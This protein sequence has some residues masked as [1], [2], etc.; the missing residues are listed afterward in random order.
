MLCQAEGLVLLDQVAIDGTKIEA[1][2]SKKQ[3]YSPE[4][5]AKDLDDAKAQMVKLHSEPGKE[6]YKLRQQTV[7][8]VFGRIKSG[9]GFIRY[10]LHD[11]NGA[12][13]EFL[14]VC[15]AHNL[16]K[17]MKGRVAQQEMSPYWLKRALLELVL[18]VFKAVLDIQNSFDQIF[19]NKRM[20]LQKSA[21]F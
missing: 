3:I 19:N 8:P 21:P 10:R 20:L 14:L 6:I 15:I 2:A 17:L 16:H 4:R 12:K 11:L 5:V 13:S 18:L 1:R 9:F 7:E